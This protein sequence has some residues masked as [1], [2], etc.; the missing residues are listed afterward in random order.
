MAATEVVG[1][2]P[3]HRQALTG[4]CAAFFT[5]GLLMG[6]WGPMIPIYAARTGESKASVGILLGVASGAGFLMVLA[7]GFLV[8]RFEIRRILQAGTLVVA[9][10]MVGLATFGTKPLLVIA[11]TL[12]G[13]G[14]ALVNLCG[15]QAL[16]RSGHPSAMTH[17]SVVN[18]VYA[19]GAVA[20]P[21]LIALGLSGTVLLTGAAVVAL[22][23]GVLL[24]SLA[25]IIPRVVG[26]RHKR[27]SSTVFIVAMF[28]VGIGGYVALEASIAGWLPTAV[29]RAG[30]SATMGAWAAT[31]FY[32]AMTIG[33][34]TVSLMGNRLRP[35]YL[36]VFAM[37]LVLAVLLVST[38]FKP[39]IGITIVGFM[40]AP[41][42]PGS[43][44][45]LARLTPGDPAPTTWLLL[46]AQAGGTIVP[47]LVGYALQDT[48]L[49]FSLLLAPIALV[50]LVA[51]SVVA[52][53]RRRTIN[54]LA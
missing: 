1:H 42:F 32:G 36:T 49:P 5:V 13:G 17:N 23:G 33:R 43:A 15:N 50:S 12:A 41:I 19:F 45:W 44:V 27:D 54:S 31:I 6:S 16:S 8:S 14:A 48:T 24:N 47:P 26:S 52:S 20:A 37:A 51:Y 9:V 4:V 34:L 35:S 3:V 53:V 2:H 40:M 30:G 10:G 21:L 11:A 29:T 38:P 39:Y 7:G 46:A 22:V 25:W 18:T 28:L